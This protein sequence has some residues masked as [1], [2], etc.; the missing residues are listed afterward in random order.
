MVTCIQCSKWLG[1]GACLYNHVIP[2][3]CGTS[4]KFDIPLD[5]MRQMRVCHDSTET[6]CTTIGG[7]G[8]LSADLVIY[9]TAIDYGINSSCFM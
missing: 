5:H 7:G 1:S 8:I 4:P 6:N 9:L 2:M 3:K